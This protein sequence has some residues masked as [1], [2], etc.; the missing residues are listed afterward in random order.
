M[1]NAIHP[2]GYLMILLA[3]VLFGTYGIWS[4][5]MGDHFGVFYQGWVR[6]L[7]VLIILSP[8]LIYKKQLRWPEK[9]DAKYLAIFLGAT[10]LTQAPL[11]YAFITTSVGIATLLFYAAFII[12]SFLIGKYLIGEKITSIKLFAMLLAFVGLT[13][14][15]GLSL[16]VFS[17]A[18]MA[19]AAL[20]G[21]ASGTE[22]SSS[23][24]L[25]HYPALL[26]TFYSWAVIL[27]THLIV[28][29]GIGEVQ[30]LPAN[31]VEWWAMLAYSLVGLISFWLVVEGFKYVDASIGSLIG[32]LEIIWAILFG[33]IFFGEHV[34]L[35]VWIGAILIVLAGFLPD[36]KNIL[37]HNR[38]K[39]PAEPPREM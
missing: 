31:T 4:K 34:G 36:A 38:T 7:V 16:S 25:S 24:K 26:V 30:W 1:K 12:A 5:L 15:F 10:L 9:K 35:T 13:F 39:Q 27:V 3:S 28:S 23:K 21:T 33:A 32:L 6:A 29:I 2:K 20:N 8:Y 14:V 19:M 17:F 11:Y 18:G 22:V 37:E